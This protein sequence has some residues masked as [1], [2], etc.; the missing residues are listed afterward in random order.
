M[1]PPN[2][3]VNRKMATVH[4]TPRDSPFPKIT[5]PPAFA[6]ARFPAPGTERILILAAMA[7]EIRVGG[8]WT[9]SIDCRIRLSSGNVTP[10]PVRWSVLPSSVLALS[11]FFQT[12][13]TAQ[14]LV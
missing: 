4:T 7:A 12:V 2:P 14:F 13:T 5:A 9:G 10:S 8:A 3:R 11:I 6:T 1:P